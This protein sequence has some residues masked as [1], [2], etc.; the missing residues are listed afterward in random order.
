MK[1][2]LIGMFAI[3]FSGLSSLSVAAEQAKSIWPSPFGIGGDHHT[4]QTP[5]KW[6]PQ[7]AAIGIKVNRSIHMN[8]DAV[9][10]REGQWEWAACDRQLQCM[11]DNG[12]ETGGIFLANPVWTRKEN[13][14]KGSVTLP[15]DNLPAWSNY[16]SEAVKRYKGKI[17]VWEVWNEPPNF[18]GSRQDA[19]DYAKV[20]SAAYDAAKAADPD[21]RVGLGVKSVHLN[22]LERAIKAGAKDKFDYVTVHPYEV[23]GGVTR[24]EG[25][26]AIFMNIV[27]SIRKMLARVNPAKADAPVVFSELGTNAALPSEHRAG[28]GPIVAAQGLVKSYAMGIA[29]GVDCI[30]WFEGM[31]GDSGAMGLLDAAG[32][33]RPSY[34]AMGQTIKH[35]GP[36]P[37]SLGWVILNG[38]HY[39]F[40]FQGAKGPVLVTWAYKGI[41]DEVDFGRDVPIVD[42]LT[43]QTSVAS[44]YHLTTAPIIVGNVPDSLVAQAKSNK[45]RPLPWVG[46]Y[47]NAKSVSITFGEK[48]VEKGLHTQAS[49][50]VAKDVLAY[51]GSC[52]SGDVPGGNIFMIDPN[53][54]LSGKPG[55][56]RISVVVRRNE[57]NDVAGFK[58]SYESANA[59]DGYT[60]APDWY[61]V[62]DNKQWHTA[63]W[64]LDD[65]QFVNMW[66]Y[67]FAL[68]SD[69]SKYNK[70][71]IQSVTVEKLP[72]K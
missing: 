71:V 70:Y 8:W 61:S 24:D 26:E 63:T 21:C 19:T 33:P 16:V 54:L 27:P 45:A 44:K 37:S 36:R 34:T 46:D 15:S 39:A 23:K 51:G 69:G 62:P 53:F 4:S 29:Q 3:G 60:T 67:S 65:A 50:A 7:M 28:L 2:I 12:V 9:E 47:S 48:T 59:R 25:T 30:Q 20:V 64:D 52:R 66:G 43:G 58:L 56:V 57:A 5:E 32:K 68:N 14:G 11:I 42:P 1:R 13:P 72:A 40:V 31:D 22:Y 55:P 49:D 6:I 35:L 18:T 38:K 17:R 41:A 10:P